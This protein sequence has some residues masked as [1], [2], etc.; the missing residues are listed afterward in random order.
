MGARGGM[1]RVVTTASGPFASAAG[2]TSRGGGGWFNIGAGSGIGGSRGGP[3]GGGSGRPMKSESKGAGFKETDGDY[4][5]EARINADKLHV[6][7]PDD[8]IDSE[9]EAMIAA[10]SSRGQSTIPMGIYRKEHKDAGVV[11][12]TTAELEAAENNTAIE[13][14]ESLFVDSGDSTPPEVQEEGVWGADTKPDVVVKPEPTDDVMDIDAAIAEKKPEKK[15]VKVKKTL[16]DPEDKVIQDDLDLLSKELGAISVEK[17]G[18]TITEPADKDG[19]LYLFQ[20]PPL[21]PPLKPTDETSTA[22]KVKPEP[23]STDAMDTG[24]VDLTEADDEDEDPELSEEQ[25]A[26]QEREQKEGFRSQL[27]SQGGMIGR[28]NVR[29]SGKVELSWGG[30]VL[31]MSPA[32]GMSF[33]TTAVIVEESDEKPTNGTVGAPPTGGEC[34]GMGKIMG[35]FTLAPVWSEEEEWV[36]A[37]E[38]LHVT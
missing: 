33:L 31:E 1:G 26:Q 13:V 36:V 7:G 25:A 32:A 5:R 8:D 27:L 29:K 3:G 34:V 16:Q 20:F 11:V 10:L 6:M 2:S 28:V 4:Y 9:D 23:G 14:E 18:E 30:R 37:D 17:D 38:E 12:A 24:A 21:M 19:R 22:P 15:I 35:R